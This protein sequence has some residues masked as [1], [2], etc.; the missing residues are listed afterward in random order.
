MRIIVKEGDNVLADMTFEDEPVTIG[1]RPE[2]NIHLPAQ[3]VAGRQ[4]V[5]TPT[6]G[7]VWH[8]E[9]LE[10]DHEIL[11]NDHALSGP[12]SLQ[13]HDEIAVQHFVLKVSLASDLEESTAEEPH[14]SADELARI[15]QY[16]VPAGSIVRRHVD[17]TSLTR[18]QL[19]RVSRV[20][21]DLAA[22][23]DLHQLVDTSLRILL[24]LFNARVAWIGLRRQAQGELEVI[25]GRL[26][27]G[28]DAGSN[29][30]IELLQYRILER[31]QHI[32]VRKIRDQEHIGSA[33]AAPLVTPGGTLGMIYVDRRVGSRRFQIPDLDLLSVLA[34]HIAA[35]VQALVQQQI[36][37]T[38]EVNATEIAVVHAIQ[39]HLDPKTS[40]SFEGF[41]LAAYSRSGQENPGDVYDVMRHPDTR[42]TAFM[43]GHVNATGA[44]LALSMARLHSTFRVGFLH[45][46][47]PHALARALNWLMYDERDPST[48]DALFLLLDPPSGKLKYARAGKVGAFIVNQEGQPRALQGAD[49]PSIGKVRGFEYV[50]RM[51]KISRGETL[52]LYTRGVASCT[53]AD[54]ERFGEHR[55]I[56]LVCDG[57][58]Q[59]AA[60]TVQDISYELTSFFADGTHPDDITIS[61]LH[62]LGR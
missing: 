24:D 13:D 49:A 46:D 34:A 12:S 48:V 61:L 22:C 1:S 50:S 45:N 11:L 62:R 40:A 42:I 35:Q 9:N 36:Q 8:I 56:E 31:S 2:C 41:Q 47:P 54:G 30:I 19:D 18:A 57:F 14:L 15:K 26:P 3:E 59:P 60:T 55:F 21:V 51:E 23:R 43:L 7:G 28:Q 39:A 33:M 25:G 10:P 37:R 52:A 32:C 58:C 6:E 5:I 44:L 4:A 29:P 16:P 20:A 38:A 53:N 27:S 17:A